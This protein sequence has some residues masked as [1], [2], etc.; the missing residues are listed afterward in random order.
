M[1]VIDDK[2]VKVT[3]HYGCRKECS[4]FFVYNIS[5]QKEKLVSA[6]EKESRAKQECKYLEKLN[7]GGKDDS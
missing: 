3:A 5:T 2:I 6:F 7:Y 1:L 4:I